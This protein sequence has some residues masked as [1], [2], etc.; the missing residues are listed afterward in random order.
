MFPTRKKYVVPDVALNANGNGHG[1]GSAPDRTL[2]S[3]FWA[4]VHAVICGT[5]PDPVPSASAVS[6]MSCEGVNAYQTLVF[7]PQIPGSS[8]ACVASAVSSESL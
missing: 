6:R 8:P 5:Y 7:V 4:P 2:L 3:A 1:S